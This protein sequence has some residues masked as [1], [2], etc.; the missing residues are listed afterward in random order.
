M[1]SRHDIVERDG[2]GRDLEKEPKNPWKWS[3]LQDKFAKVKEMGKWAEKTEYGNLA[4]N[5]IG[6]VFQ[7]GWAFCNICDEAVHY[8]SSGVN[9]LQKHIG[10]SKHVG[11]RR[12]VNTNFR[13]DC[14]CPHPPPS[15]HTHFLFRF[16]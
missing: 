11:K 14:E 3:W 5:G 6:K 16:N 1:P 9:D 2:G 12:T 7:A 15:T 8:S 13:M 10:T 4:Q